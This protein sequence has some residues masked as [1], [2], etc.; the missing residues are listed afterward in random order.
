LNYTSDHVQILVFVIDSTVHMLHEILHIDQNARK[1]PK[2]KA[3]LN[4]GI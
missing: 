1:P 3:H 2:R 4:M